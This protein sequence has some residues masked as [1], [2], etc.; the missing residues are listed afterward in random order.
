MTAQRK[1]GAAL[2]REIPSH[3]RDHYYSDYSA[4]MYSRNGERAGARRFIVRPL[5]VFELKTQ[6]SNLGLW[7]ARPCV[8]SHVSLVKGVSQPKDTSQAVSLHIRAKFVQLSEYQPSANNVRV[9][10]V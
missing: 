8:T 5:P 6:I 4:L 7:A 10:R 1:L 3:S 2:Y 9:A